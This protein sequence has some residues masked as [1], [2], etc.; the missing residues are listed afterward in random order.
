[1]T[2]Q[3]MEALTVLMLLA[4]VAGIVVGMMGAVL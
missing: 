4:F 2:Q 1:M 3:G